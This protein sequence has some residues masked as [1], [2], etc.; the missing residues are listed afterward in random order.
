MPTL[1]IVIMIILISLIVYFEISIAESR[2]RINAQEDNID[3]R[4]KLAELEHDQWAH[5]TVY[6]LNNL[7]DKNIERWQRQINIPYSELTET[8]K[9]S[10]RAWADKVLKIVREEK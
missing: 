10:D 5:W 9:D 1:F 7:T 4:E 2:K 6:F 8:E 3:S